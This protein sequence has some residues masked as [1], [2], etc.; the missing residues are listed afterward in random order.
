MIIAS[1]FEWATHQPLIRAVMDI[2]KPKFVLELGIGLYST[3]VFFEYRT[4]YLGIENNKEWIDE[5]GK[6]YI[7][8]FI[9]HDL[10]EITE[11]TGYS[12]LTEK[13]KQEIVSFYQKLNIYG[14][15]LRLLFVDQFT[16]CRTISIN[17]LK[18]KFDLIIYHDSESIEVNRYDLIDFTGFRRYILKTNKTCTTLMVKE[19]QLNET[20]QPYIKVFQEVN[21]DCTLMEFIND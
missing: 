10:G 13:Q 2:Y 17:T 7:N 1:G 3:P 15:G 21:K 4:E 8:S 5:M 6:K 14:P 16:S 19:K 11:G 20:I 12:E 18:D 9:Y